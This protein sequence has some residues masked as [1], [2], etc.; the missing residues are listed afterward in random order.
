MR[1]P[2]GVGFGPR[3]LTHITPVRKV[4]SRSNHKMTGWFPSLKNGRM[5]PYRSKNERN[6][7]ALLET[8]N[9]VLEFAAQPRHFYYKYQ[10]K[11]RRYTPDTFERYRDG[12]TRYTEVKPLEV[13]ADID[14]ART[15]SAA[16]GW[17]KSEGHDFKIVTDIDIQDGHRLKNAEAMLRSANLRFTER[18]LF[19]VQDALTGM[20]VAAIGDL[21]DHLKLPEERRGVIHVMAI[22]GH[23][24]IDI[25]S[26]PL[27]PDTAVSQF[28]DLNKD[29]RE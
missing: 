13:L 5:I 16:G 7:F 9:Q 25:C 26:A 15:L 11:K 27:S 29:I 20:R 24:N 23:I 18:Q 21:W 8:C 17:I 10:G 19:A 6:W 1:S 2:D 3:K 22:L 12:R 28:F 14:V 4:V